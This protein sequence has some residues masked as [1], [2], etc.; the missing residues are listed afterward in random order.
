MGIE[1]DQLGRRVSYW[2][3]REHPGEQFM[4]QSSFE[5]VPVPATEV[6][7]AFRPLR[8]GQARGVP[9][10]TAI[11]V[12]LNDLDQYED[13]ELVRKKTAAMFGGFITEPA[14]EDVGISPLGVRG[15]P[16]GLNREVIAMEPGTFPTLPPGMDVRF[17]TPAD[18]GPNYE[19]WIKQEMKY[20]LCQ[21]QK[22]ADRSS[23][24]GQIQGYSG[25]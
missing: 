2:F 19:V 6:L 11:I 18:V 9:W 10:L 15:G 25:G 24:P 12:Q 3:W 16:D 8:P 13:A 22:K 23:V 14:G 7:H 1:F 20:H 21:C 4:F 5:R 17:S